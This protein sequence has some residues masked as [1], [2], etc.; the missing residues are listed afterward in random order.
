[1]LFTNITLVN[2]SRCHIY[3]FFQT[4]LSSL[5]L[6]LFLIVGL[7]MLMPSGTQAGTISA[8]GPETYQRSN[9]APLTVTNNFS[10]PRPGDICLARIYNGGMVDADYERVSSSVIMFNGSEIFSPNE[11]NQQVNYLEKSVTMAAAN[12]LD[13]E[14]RGKPGGALVLIIECEAFD[15]TPPTINSTVNPA[16]NG[17]GWHNTDLTVSFTCSDVDSAIASCSGPS[18]II[19]EGA[20]QAVTGTAEDTAGN[21]ATIDVTINLDKT[22]P[23]LT[24]SITPPVN[25]NGWYES[26]V[27]IQY[28]CDDT[29]SGVATC[30]SASTTV[31]EGANQVVSV[32]ATDIAG[33]TAS[34]STILNVDKFAPSITARAAPIAN[35]QG[36]NNTDVMVS[37]DCQDTGSGIASCMTPITVTID[38]ANQAV[39]GTAQDV[40][41]KTTTATLKLNIDKTAPTITA[42]LSSQPNTQGWH[43]SD[44]VVTFVCND[45]LSGVANCPAP[46]TV[47]M[48]AANQ[49]INGTTTDR[50]GNSASVSITLNIDKTLP[51][52]SGSALPTANARGWS[53]SDVTVSF[54]CQDSGSGIASCT[55]PKTVTTEG[56]VQTITGA[57][58]DNAGNTAS[59]DVMV[60]LDKTAPTLGQT[61]SPPANANGWHTSDVTIQYTCTDILSG[62]DS[63]PAVKTI[64]TEGINQ[65]ISE[66]IVDNADNSTTVSTTLSID[67]TA[68]IITAELSTPANAQG[69][70]TADVTIT[71]SCNDTGSG[72]ENCPAPITV[73]TEGANQIFT[74]SVSDQAGNTASTTITINLDKT[75]PTIGVAASPLANAGGW[76]N[77]AVTVTFD[78]QDTG[79][80]LESCTDTVI[81]SSDGAN[82][83]ITGQVVDVSGNVATASVTINLDKTAPLVSVVKTPQ[84]NANGWNDTD[85]NVSF[86]CSDALSGVTTCPDEMT[87]SAEGESSGSV[88]ASDAAGN[89][90]IVDYTVGIDKSD[91]TIDA[92]PVPGPNAAGWNNTNVTVKFDCSDTVSGVETCTAPI[93]L[94]TEGAGQVAEGI[95]TD[96]VGKSATASVTLNIDKTPPVIEI[97]TPINAAAIKAATVL[98]EGT[99]SDA[100][101]VTLFSINGQNVSLNGNQ[102]SHQFNLNEG[103]NALELVA[104]DI[105]NNQSAAF[106]TITQFVNQPPVITSQAVNSA[107]QLVAYEYQVVATDPDQG[108]QLVYSLAQAPQGMTIDTS[109]GLINWIPG[110][111]QLGDFDVS[112]VVRDQDGAQDNQQ[113]VVTIQETPSDQYACGNIYVGHKAVDLALNNDGS[114]IFVVN[115]PSTLSNTSQGSVSVL[116]AS[117]RAAIDEIALHIGFTTQIDT[118]IARSKAYVAISK[119]MGTTDTIGYSSI[120]VIDTNTHAVIK[121]I[122]LSEQAGAFGVVGAKTR[123]KVYVT[124]RFE[125]KVYVIDTN[126]DTI[127]KRVP[128][129]GG[130]I[131]IDISVDEKFVYAMGRGNSVIY[132]IDADTNA[133]VDT[134]A[135]SVTTTNDRNTIAVSPNGKYLYATSIASSTISIIDTDSHSA[136]Y[137]QEIA[138]VSTPVSGFYEI[139]SSLDGRL[140][141]AASRNDNKVLVIDIN[142]D[143]ATYLSVI[144]AFV[145]G[146]SPRAIVVGASEYGLGYIAN[147]GTRNLTVLC[148]GNVADNTPPKITSIPVILAVN[149]IAYQY[150]VT[151]HD[152]DPFDELIF[153]LIESPTAMS[154]DPQSGVIDWMPNV[155]DVGSH[156]VTVRVT[157]SYGFSDEQAYSIT[158]ELGNRSPEIISAAI[159]S[160]EPKTAYNYDVDA[161]DPDG[162]LLTYE[163]TN[164]PEGMVI[165]ST[166]GIISWT[167]TIDQLGVHNVTVRVTDSSGTSDTQSYELNVAA[168]VSM[169]GEITTGTRI[170]DILLSKDKTDLFGLYYPEQD[171]NA[172][173]SLKIFDIASNQLERE[174]PLS[175]GFSRDLALSEDGNTI[176]VV[177]SKWAGS[178][179]TNGLNHVAVVDLKNNIVTKEIRL[180]DI[181]AT[182]IELTEKIGKAFVVDRTWNGIGLHVIDLVTQTYSRSIDIPGEPISLSSTPDQTRLYVVSRGNSSE[183]SRVT[184]VDTQAESVIGTVPVSIGPSRGG[185]AHIKLAPSGKIGLVSFNNTNNIS[186]IS[187]DPDSPNYNQQIGLVSL[188]G[189]KPRSIT[190]SKDGR[191]AYVGMQGSSSVSVIDID[192][193]SSNYLTEIESIQTVS[194]TID[195]I[196][197]DRPDV[198]AYATNYTTDT[199]SAICADN[200]VSNTGP[201]IVS[202]PILN[203][204]LGSAYSYDVHA[205]DPDS[206]DL[207][208]FEL[209][210]GPEGMTIDPLTGIIEFDPTD[211]G[212]V[213]QHS[214]TVQ[215]TDRAGA[216]DTQIY[217]LAVNPVIET[218]SVSDETV[219]PV[220]LSNWIVE[221]VPGTSGSTP[222]WELDTTGYV[223]HQLADSQPTNFMSPIDMSAGHI[224]GTLRVADTGD[225]DNI[226]IT[227]GYQDENHYYFLMWN[228][229]RSTGTGWISVRRVNNNFGSPWDG[230]ETLY[231]KYGVPWQPQVEY[232]YDFEFIEGGFNIVIKDNDTLIDNITIDDTTFITGRFGFHGTSQGDVYYTANTV[233]SP[234]VKAGQN[235]F[236]KVVSTPVIDV[237]VNTQYQYQV[238]ALDPDA[239]D[240]I[241]YSLHD[242]PAGMTIDSSAG[243]ITYNPTAITNNVHRI[244]VIATDNH[245]DF[246]SQTYY[247]TVR[248]P[249]N[250]PVFTTTPPITG[251]VGTPY[252][253]DADATDTDGDSLIF[254]FASNPPPSMTLDG[255][256][257]IVNWTPTID[258]VGINEVSIRV[259][260]GRNVVVQHFVIYVS[261]YTNNSP[262]ITS[263]PTLSATENRLYIYNIEALD[264]NGDTLTYSLTTAPVGMSINS[265]TGAVS[266]TPAVGQAGSHDVAISVDDGRGG[267]ATQSFNIIVEVAQPN[268]GPQIISEPVF[269]AKSGYQYQYQVVATDA[270]NDQLYYDVMESPA[271]ITI[272]STGLLTWTPTDSDIG[273]HDI[274]V[275]VN[276]TQLL[277]NQGWTLTVVDG[278]VPVEVVLDINPSSIAPNETVTITLIANNV[279]GSVTRSAT[280]DGIGVPLDSNGVGQVSLSNIGPHDVI[281]TVTDVSGTNIANATLYVRDPNDIT[282]PIVDITSPVTDITV[283]TNADITGSV[284]DANLQSYVLAYAP[285]GSSNFVTLAE[286]S[287]EFP[288][289][290]IA[291][292]DA[293]QLLNGLY[294]IVLQATDQSGQTSSDTIQVLVDGN[295]KV[296]NF[297]FTVVDLEIPVSGIPIRVTRTYDSR[298]KHEDLDFGYGWTI[299]YQ[300]VKIEESRTPGQGWALN[301]YPSGPLGLIPLWCVE[302]LGNLRVSVTLPDGDVETFKVQATPSCAQSTP[303]LDVRLNFVPEAGT[304]GTLAAQSDP[305]LRLSNGHL[306]FLGDGVPY[307]TDRYVYTS[308]EGFE[309]HLDQNF[310]IEMVKDL[311]GNTLTYTDN[312]I[313]HSDGKSV[314]FNRDATGRITSITDPMNNA[315][316]YDYDGEGNL[317]AYT[318]LETQTT[319]Y[320]YVDGQSFPSLAHSLL[321]IIDPLGRGVIKNIYDNDGRLIAQEDADGVRTEFDYNIDGRESVVSNRRGYITRYFYDDRGN[322]TVK[323]DADGATVYEYDADDNLLS[324]MNPLGEMS[325]ASYDERRNQLTQTND[326]GHTVRFDY[327]QR[328]QETRIY[329]ARGNL[330]FEN[331]YDILGNLRVV[332]DPLGNVAEQIVNAKG[333]VE[334]R[335]DALL[336]E[337]RFSYGSTGNKLTET[338][339]QGNTITFSYDANGNVKTE[340]RQRT[341]NGIVVT[342]T[343]LYDYDK[344]NRLI[345]I[346]DP[347]GQRTQVEYDAAGNESARIDAKGQRTDFEYDAYR[348]L[349]QTRYADGSTEHNQYDAEGNLILS[350]DRLGRNTQY[351]YDAMNR[352]TQVIYPDGSFMQTQYDVAGR[353]IAEI[354][355]RGNRTEHQYDRAGRRTLSRN[356]DLNETVF[357]YDEDG[358]LISQTDAKQHTTT[359]EYDALD[360][361]RKTIFHDNSEMLEAYDA[362]GRLTLKTDQSNRKTQY[363]YDKLGRLSTVISAHQTALE[364]TTSYTYDEVGNKLKQIDANL[365]ETTWTY[366]ALGRVKTR[367]L[368]EGQQESFTYD[369]N[370]NQKTHMDFD[371]QQTTFDYDENDRLTQVTYHDGNTES[372][373]YYA[374]GNRET[375]TDARG[376]TSYT[377]D[378]RDRL[379][380]ETQPDGTVLT[381]DYDEA[382]NRTLLQTDIP[383]ASTGQTDTTVTEY[384]YDHLNRLDTVTDHQQQV[385]SYTYDAVG[386]RE[387]VTYANGTSTTYVYDA[388]NRLETLQTVDSSNTII[389]QFDYTVYPTGHR[390][391]LTDLAGNVSTYLYD[392]LYRVTQE[393]INHTTLGTVTNSYDY[394]AVG[395]RQSSTENGITTTYTYDNNDRMLSSLKNGIITTYTYD[396]NGNTLSKTDN[397]ATTNTSQFSYD[398]KNKLIFVEQ[399]QNGAPT[400]SVDYQY[401][402]DG[403]R[404][405][406]ADNS[407]IIHFVVD[408]NQSFAQVVHEL[409]DQHVNQV[410]YTHGDDLISQDRQQ[411]INYYHYDGLGSTRS[412]T[413]TAG[414]ITDTYEYNAY[415][416]I[417]DQ[418]GSTAN[419]YLYTGEQ[420]DAALDNYYLRAR[421]YDPGSGRFTAMDTFQGIDNEPVT[422]NKYLYANADPVNNI[423]PSGRFS[424]SSQMVAVSTI[425]I[426]AV[427]S[428]HSYQIGQ[429][430]AGTWNN[431]G[432]S[433]TQAGWLVIAAMVGV[434]SNVLELL[435][436]K[437]DERDEEGRRITLYHGTSRN[438][439][440]KILKKGFRNTPVFFAEDRVTAHT[441][442]RERAAANGSVN[443]TVL[444][445]NVPMSVVNASGMRRGIIG[446]ELGLGFVD[447]PG[448]TGYEW[449]ITNNLGLQVFNGSLLTGATTVR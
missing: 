416:T 183:N 448:G 96:Y 315:M 192:P 242:V 436:T 74:G 119:F 137:R 27:T 24:T 225:D 367:T 111:T 8:F 302:P 233:E 152:P 287:M 58:I 140:L 377:Y 206:R 311:N 16:A 22:A 228:N 118:N 99:V 324:T 11:F 101:P 198:V 385:T 234:C 308:K 323:V 50:A 54:D 193:Y 412:L 114:K 420:F 316:H 443:V 158:V 395:N 221:N 138:V 176:Y 195:V 325:T 279:V 314:L 161:T 151:V 250:I 79:S 435:Q 98:V 438:A 106:L 47:T 320:T 370:G 235:H 449:F 4:K 90:A 13:V 33:N 375:A 373:S 184:V 82:Q 281:A 340:T 75:L 414:L 409:N 243:L 104:T 6:F 226:G 199:V 391:T 424:I 105:A 153:E 85:V 61:V 162:D 336:G 186:V 180:P 278:N 216:T 261:E 272:S 52:I 167:P 115:F 134:I 48:E 442:G 102:F 407:G 333:L 202:L 28:T 92:I 63:C 255:V 116:D 209:I 15:T 355:A 258:Q 356:A 57:A 390:H 400:N 149:D 107:V 440:R 393:I 3:N 317:E 10:Y 295:L 388:L 136:T 122:P 271:G 379:K 252:I 5:H 415:G 123:N 26:D 365:N 29:L 172:R 154:I 334:K 9:G 32:T 319:T 276:D 46:V 194:D 380:T 125:N 207:L 444:T 293:T 241:T 45:N 132:V 427:S 362:L 150:P 364:T 240:T 422:L 248:E 270:N 201:T 346:T 363:H 169:C 39:T 64:A 433:S 376:S 171:V 68:P 297:S 214:I 77:S 446:E 12:Q 56:D 84:A 124:A 245:G 164:S 348:R 76:N 303:V 413:D 130:P 185:S 254:E 289:Q 217:S 284:S 89:S 259:Q 144:N 117:T 383:N 34:V 347:L 97:A 208:T 345:S 423:D 387:T 421:Y 196:F 133:V 17:N 188:T 182:E 265:S 263:T 62:V 300:D 88:V 59:S 246:G 14:V 326:L 142:P 328:G 321:D 197:Q 286:G 394:N 357:A 352:Q 288:E 95:V 419:S 434:G 267:I 175:T 368:P 173:G 20:N 232:T 399:R 187:V 70:H 190:I 147:T 71:F 191:L 411:S 371:G 128:V 405:Q 160:V 253:Y 277:Q 298:R 113:Y 329:D 338:D 108:D 35:A 7:A 360:R 87:Y 205:S 437:V 220:N 369:E 425:G 127:V 156:A 366:D 327:N 301:Q 204:T 53:N 36:W 290:T 307:N 110:T 200:V 224:R 389:S 179:T 42:Q 126:T 51:N 163:L 146:V 112:V 23:S 430:L 21:I 397:S 335:I 93:N 392:E 372:Y 257:G 229:Q 177:V 1:M 230:V 428:Q 269:A 60:N 361:R 251:V 237:L 249:N 304:L 218:C 274:I 189:S 66:T 353:V 143:S 67:K 382:G 260:D 44:V 349:I 273:A 341:D 91:P 72:I 331:S 18:T 429:S 86:V 398:A 378:D 447:V 43:T 244:T 275:R 401:D 306:E 439:G 236:P 351:R 310:G 238:Q 155:A 239:G 332:K 417:L 386:N 350:I 181:A 120:E 139:V 280:V 165:D 131:G 168:I 299:G 313:L 178:T 213:G 174:F 374:N 109:S 402:V 403:H 30:P 337:T 312:G 83:V 37:L 282:A 309:Y 344:L 445:F 129:D 135:S 264:S 231:V 342:E 441:F 410:T 283:T 148:G 426:L 296:G 78:C 157:D 266:W 170:I 292:F 49:L 343:T 358:N 80:G 159:I 294:T 404:T 211:L 19:T 203:V 215:V 94:A 223:A 381:Y 247:L 396:D 418:S 384:T 40:S 268:V 432:L 219:M 65:V 408:R 2:F 210:A 69:W 55:N 322:V 256:T 330:P 305:L 227:F 121:S 406:K 359:F 73:S 38:G 145:D 141:Y 318:D 25:A 103:V 81:V 291:T 41:G 431:D 31:T 166:T 285:A 222:V 339:A 100:N 354:D 212:L 262:S